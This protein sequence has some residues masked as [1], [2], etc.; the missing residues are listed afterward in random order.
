MQIQVN[1][2]H[3]VE[4]SGIVERAENE[5]R[6]T[7]GR[8]DDMVTRV[9][10]HL[11]DMNGAKA[12]DHDKRCMMEARLRGHQPVAVTELSGSM[13]QSIHNAAKKLRRA[14]DH[15]L[16]RIRDAHF[17]DSIRTDEAITADGDEAAAS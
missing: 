3:S 5:V 4:G 16:G 2:N 14:I 7:L 11:N 17:G 9:E 1:T 10:V 15:T 13:E 8:F 6:E 12:G